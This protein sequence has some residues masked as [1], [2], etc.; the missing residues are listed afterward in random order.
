LTEFFF[1][2]FKYKALKYLYLKKINLELFKKGIISN[3]DFININITTSKLIDLIQFK[4]NIMNVYDE[5]R[6]Y[7]KKYNELY[8]FLKNVYDHIFSILYLIYNHKDVCNIKSLINYNYYD[9]KYGF[10]Y[11]IL[12][13]ILIRIFSKEYDISINYEGFN[14]LD[15]FF[16]IN[17]K[18]KKFIFEC[19]SK[20]IVLPIL[21]HEDEQKSHA[22]ILIYNPNTKEVE[23][24]EPHGKIIGTSYIFSRFVLEYFPKG[25]KYVPQSYLTYPIQSMQDQDICTIAG[26]CL[27][28]TI[29]YADQRLNHPTLNAKEAFKEIMEKHKDNKSENYLTILIDSYVKYVIKQREI[30][31]EKV[32][33]DPE[34]KKILKEKWK[35]N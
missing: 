25:T 31:L 1:K 7:K 2:L 22:N 14:V 9:I 26:H 19:K 35:I 21:I 32:D 23:I 34:I 18:L 10:F 8:T 29:W 15:K 3:F 13:Y 27:S 33:I 6:Y 24:F 12:K 16:I 4:H 20:F 11:D 17:K 30:V 28:W 5:S